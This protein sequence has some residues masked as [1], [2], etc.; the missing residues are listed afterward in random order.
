M[1]R[2]TSICGRR[3]HAQRV[4]IGSVTASLHMITIISSLMFLAVSAVTD[5]TATNE[6]VTGEPMAATNAM[7]ASIL[8]SIKWLVDQLQPLRDVWIGRIMVT[9]GIV[10]LFDVAAGRFPF[11]TRFQQQ[12]QQQERQ[13]TPPPV[14]SRGIRNGQDRDDSVASNS[15]SVLISS[16]PES[17]NDEGVVRNLS[18]DG[19]SS[20][21]EIIAELTENASKRSPKE[22]HKPLPPEDGGGV[23]SG[24]SSSSAASGRSLAVCRPRIVA[25]S[26]R[27]HGMGDFAQ[28]YDV[29][30][31]LYRIYTLTRKDG[32]QVVPP[33]ILSSNRGTVSI[34]LHVTNNTNHTINV[35]WV[36]YKGKHILK[37]K[38]NP[39]QV[40]TQTTWIDHRECGS[41][42]CVYSSPVT[43]LPVLS[44][45]NAGGASHRNVSHLPQY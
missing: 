19:V 3:S 12:Q 29:E 18:A 33:Y 8:A 24:G 34:F 17:A 21:T 14:P 35:Y 25:A 20:N 28:W 42:L 45:N 37:W 22:G 6:E 5:A 36:D 43:T 11:K 10:L 30:T 38:M 31:S 39:N 32:V 44:S 26:N 2:S 16:G 1:T 4:G 23:A 15:T 7:S 27:H 40:W 13:P 41:A 9:I